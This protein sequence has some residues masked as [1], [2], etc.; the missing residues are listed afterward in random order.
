MT[1][2][3]AIN[4]KQLTVHRNNSSNKGLP[5]YILAGEQ[6][7][8]ENYKKP[9]TDATAEKVFSEGVTKNLQDHAP[10]ESDQEASHR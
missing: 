1:H 9:K 4:K 6:K 8:D 5:R 10:Y 2:D 3:V 7:V